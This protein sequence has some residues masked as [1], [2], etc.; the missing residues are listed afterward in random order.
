MDANG[1]TFIA[2]IILFMMFYTI[3]V[4]IITSLIILDM[5]E[6]VTEIKNKEE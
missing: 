6:K 4:V 3:V 2:M 5:F 1:L